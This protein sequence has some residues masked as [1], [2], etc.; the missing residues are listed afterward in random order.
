MLDKLVQL[1]PAT[2][3]D[4][5]LLGQLAAIGIVKGKALQAGRQDAAPSSPTPPPWATLPDGR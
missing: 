3:F 5:E 4:P 2:S 1:E